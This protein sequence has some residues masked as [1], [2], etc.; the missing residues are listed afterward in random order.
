MRVYI[1]YINSID[2]YFIKI[3]KEGKSQIFC[4]SNEVKDSFKS[5]LRVRLMVYVISTSLMSV[6]VGKKNC[7]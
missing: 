5:K 2:L 1:L 3:R 6:G 7:W 4:L